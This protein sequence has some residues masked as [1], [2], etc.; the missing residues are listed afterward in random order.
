MDRLRETPLK[1]RAAC[2]P[3]TEGSVRLSGKVALVTGASRGI[4][5]EIALALG[6]SGASVALVARSRAALEGVAATIGA[7]RALV[8]PADLSDL[9][10]VRAAVE[11]TLNR[12]GRIDVLVNNAGMLSGIDFLQTEPETLARTVDVNFRAAVVLTRLAAA[13]MAAQRSG[14]IVNVASLAGVTGLPGEA[15]YAGTK[16]ALR[17]FTAS[18]RLELAPHRI[19]LTDVVLGFIGTDMLSEV[20]SNPRVAG[21]FNRARRL[22]MMVDTPSEDVA[23]AVVRAIERRQDVV[24]LPSRARYLYLPLQ[25]MSRTIAQLL[26]PR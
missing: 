8:A 5:R 10:Q 11:Q 23:A 19:R 17:L 18:L 24:V 9:A 20:E 1:R 7:D 13:Q 14:H 12:F 21:M 25:G 26:A 3:A 4:G 16:A 15:T 22:R 2:R 6:R